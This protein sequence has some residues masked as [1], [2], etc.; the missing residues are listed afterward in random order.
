MVES[1][2]QYWKIKAA[3]LSREVATVQI[4]AKIKEVDDAYRKAMTDAG[5]D[6]AKNYRLSDS[7]ESVTE[8]APA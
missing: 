5:L 2:P 3:V 8:E 6:P 1:H 7:E 4:T